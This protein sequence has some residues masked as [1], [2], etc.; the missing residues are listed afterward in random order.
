MAQDTQKQAFGY[1]LITFFFFGSIYVAGKLIAND[2]PP[3]FVAAIRCILALVPLGIMAKKYWHLPI[4][5]RDKKTLF[6]IGFLG[7]FVNIHFLQIGIKLT[8]A[9]VAAL[10]NALTPVAVTFLAAFIL[11]EKITPVKYL[12]LILAIAGTAVITG[13]TQG[14]GEILGIIAVLSAVVAFSAA[15]VLMRRV[16]SKYPPILVTFYS[17]LVGAILNIP[18]AI[19]MVNTTT[20]SITTKLVGSLLWLSFIGAG[21]AQFTWAKCLSMLPAS[22]CSLFYPLQAVFAAIL[23]ALILGE[24]FTT[25]FFIGLVLISA[26]IVIS[27]RE[28]AKATRE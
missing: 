12:C 10:I 25:S 26:D 14:K 16:T 9:S 4:D 3:A 19:Y 8:G 20:V 24:T 6:L 22:T 23:G 5:K 11:R 15:S 2:L 1:L 18:V 7:Y 28:A 13:T 21:V 27:A 17:M